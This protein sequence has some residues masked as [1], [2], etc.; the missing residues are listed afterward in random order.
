MRALRADKMTYA[1]LEATLQ[2]YV[3]GRAP[4]NVPVVRMLALT[5]ADIAARATGIVQSLSANDLEVGV[6]R[7]SSTVGG[8][9]APGSSL[10]TRLL[11]ISHRTL[12]AMD[13][14]ARL[15]AWDPPIV[16]R[17]EHDR[18]VLDLRTVLPDQDGILTQALSALAS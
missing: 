3:A 10:P 4:R 11:A 7:G 5:E 18:L 14:E 9:S 13:L 2:E 8:G 1:A 6:V 17:I 12:S 15:R 16:A